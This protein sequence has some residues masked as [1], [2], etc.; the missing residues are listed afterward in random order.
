[1]STPKQ[2]NFS[3]IDLNSV[4]Y[5]RNFLSA[6]HIRTNQLWDGSDP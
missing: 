2:N 1:M 3:H 6:P 5:T 4:M